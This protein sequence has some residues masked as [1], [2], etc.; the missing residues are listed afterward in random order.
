MLCGHIPKP[1]NVGLAITVFAGNLRQ[2]PFLMVALES[3][4]QNTI[5]SDASRRGH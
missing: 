1:P 4:P 2:L 5:I 3:F